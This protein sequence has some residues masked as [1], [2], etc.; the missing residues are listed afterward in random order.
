MRE[1]K[2]AMRYLARKTPLNILK[3]GL[4]TITGIPK[5]RRLVSKYTILVRIPNFDLLKDHF[6]DRY[7]FACLSLRMV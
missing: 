5:E 1:V 7:L 6:P 2:L 3:S 4:K